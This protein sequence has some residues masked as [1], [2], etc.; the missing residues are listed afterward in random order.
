MVHRGDTDTSGDVA[1]SHGLDAL[2]RTLDAV[3]DHF[4]DT[5]SQLHR[6][7]SPGGDHL[8]TGPQ[9]GS[10][11]IDLDR[12][13]VAA[14]LDNLADKPHLAHVYHVEH[15]GVAHSFRHNQGTGDLHDLSLA[16][17]IHL[18]Y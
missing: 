11:L 4:Q 3:V 13:L 7:G 6:K 9:A 14:H 17:S 18:L 2:Q 10:L 16:Q 15:I 1:A 8:G 5:G 12:S